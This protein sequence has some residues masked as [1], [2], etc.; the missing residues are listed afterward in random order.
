MPFIQMGERRKE[1]PTLGFKK[2]IW[3]WGLAD[4]IFC[5]QQIK[6]GTGE[7]W[8]CW[9]D[10][11][12]NDGDQQREHGTRDKHNGESTTWG[13]GGE[14]W[15]ESRFR[16]RWK[17]SKARVKAAPGLG[18]F[19]KWVKRRE[20]APGTHTTCAEGTLQ[21]GWEWSPATEKYPQGLVNSLVS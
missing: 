19:G 18:V 1:Q 7:E 21:S 17:R 15:L 9:H 10:Y 11:D 13:V 12:N 14:C 5:N 8:I 20:E 3:A 6:S 16:L 4:S 2:W